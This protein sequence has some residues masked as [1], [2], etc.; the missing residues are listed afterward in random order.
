MIGV[1]RT[2]LVSW[3]STW[4]G[5]VTIPEPAAVLVAALLISIAILA[6]A[7]GAAAVY[8]SPD[9]A[10]AVTDSWALI[11][12]APRTLIYLPA[13]PA[14][15]LPFLLLGA[16]PVIAVQ[17]GL[18]VVLTALFVA[19]YGLTR[20]YVGARAAFVGAATGVGSTP[21]GELLGWQGGATLVGLVAMACALAAF[22][23]W[24]RRRT[25][26]HALFV[27]TIF[28]LTMAAHPFLTAVAAGLLGLRWLVSLRDGP[29]GVRGWGPG[30]L[31]GL[32]V[33]A[34]P[35]LVAAAWLVGHYLAIDAPAGSSL[36]LPDLAEPARL[37]AW[38]TREGPALLALGLVLTVAAL[39]APPAQR[40][41]AAGI[42][43][44]FVIIPA[45]LSGDVS[46]QS[47]VV[48]LL[49]ILL[50]IGAATL[51]EAA[52]RAVILE[53]I[54]SPARGLRERLRAP[55]AAVLVAALV[56]LLGF[57][58][59]LDA[60]VPYY[61]ALDGQDIDLLTSLGA[62]EGTIAT[63]WTG[64]RYWDG[65]AMAW[66]A[67]GLTN[68]P[69]IGPTDPAMST[70]DFQRVG[71]AA[72]WQLFS[73]EAGVE[74]GA[75]QV[76]FGPPAWRS[77]PAIAGRIGGYYIPLV[78]LSDTVNQYAP[79]GA[80][81]VGD[82]LAWTVA[83]DGTATGVRTSA[84]RRTVE[85]AVSLLGE[86]VLLRLA[87][88][89]GDANE[90]WTIW[91]WPAYG[92]PWSE[93]E[94][95]AEAREASFAPL[96]SVAVRSPDTWLAADPR[97]RVVVAEPASITYAERE[98]RFGLQALAITVPGGSDLEAT[99]TVTGLPAAGPVTRYDELSLIA[100][101]GISSALVW[102]DTGWTDRFLASPCFV[103]GPGS[104]N[105]ATFDVAPACRR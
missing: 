21:I 95:D 32:A 17:A 85:A 75:L 51:W 100:D 66:Y 99:I 37:V 102:R 65:M 44:V 4:A 70:R 1:A 31:A 67:S 27:G 59:R 62:G 96:G 54:A 6:L 90:V 79:E 25:G 35:V 69:A 53:D 88:G 63:S 10:H 14:V 39:A 22:E 26:R 101:H 23:R 12:Q 45:G 9:G 43:A 34:I 49:P 73:G 24:T 77:D 48:Y 15:L 42:V 11:G 33:A 40:T 91:V 80:L 2:R 29:R 94:V 50:S 41:I 18:V 19:L 56:V 55:A 57:P 58:G 104:A 78:Y 3:A 81:A 36:R 8:L 5:G 13:W 76:A 82:P 47:R 87:R 86:R 89:P 30:S 83:S 92:L 61:A 93:V 16:S 105:I 84:G 28:A 103:P 97:V 20:P 98:S 60:A 64:N 71:G 52:D 38:I 72:A 68:R 7:R 46:Y 74:N